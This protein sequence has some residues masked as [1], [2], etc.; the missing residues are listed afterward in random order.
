MHDCAAVVCS[1]D[2]NGGG[3]LRQCWDQGMQR[4]R[5]QAGEAGS[6]VVLI[7]YLLRDFSKSDIATKAGDSR[8]L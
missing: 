7:Q 5:K 4:G 8:G 3:V 1:W 6:R 2:K